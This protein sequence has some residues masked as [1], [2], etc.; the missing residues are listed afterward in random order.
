MQGKVMFEANTT[1][2][3]YVG[4]DVCK[5]RLDVYL[6]PV[7]RRLQVDN[8]RLGIKRLTRALAGRPVA[9]IVMEAT[10]K[11]HRLAH[12][13]LAAGG[14]A[15]AIVNPLR[16][17]LFAEA[18]GTLAKT[19][20]I[21]AKLLAVLGESLEPNVTPPAAQGLEELQELVRARQAAV[22]E[23]S[24]ISNQR[25]SAQTTFL[26]AELAR[27]Q[28]N[29]ASY[30]AR[31]ETEIDRRIEADPIL[32]RRRQILRSI[33]GVGPVAAV[34]LII[35]LSEIGDCSAKQAS[36]L[37]GLAPIARDSGEMTGQRH[38]RGGRAKVRTAIYMAAVAAAR[39]N[40]QLKAFYKRLRLNGK[41][42]KLALTAVMRK[43]VV[44]AN[45]LIR[46]NR[47]WNPIH[48]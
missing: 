45:T 5:D 16:A 4:I 1:P 35:G 6:H 10:G 42:A 39:A 8:D 13:A 14:F 19:D 37:A 46:E 27:R 32:E 15:V 12:R 28:K 26:K 24:A 48:A 38:I 7:G 2:P 20:A 36:M 30:I 33:P 25:N 17:R 34:A 3:V 21:D 18:A 11:Y 23:A 41:P 44:L 47:L 31:L 43:I 29:L 22:A 40:P 9:L